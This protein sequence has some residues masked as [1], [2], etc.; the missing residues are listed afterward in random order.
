MR[1]TNQSGSEFTPT[2]S[3]G[4]AKLAWM[5]TRTGNGDLYTATAPGSWPPAIISVSAQTRVTSHNAI[6]AF[7]D[8]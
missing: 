4:A 6:D 5:S 2:W 8:W 1:L 3:P 7:P